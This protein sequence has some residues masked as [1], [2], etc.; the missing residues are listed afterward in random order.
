MPQNHSQ[1]IG[2]GCCRVL[3][4]YW[5]R[6]LIQAL[7]SG[8][9]EDLVSCWLLH[10]DHCQF[11]AIWVLPYGNSQHDNLLHQR[12][13]ERTR[14]RKQE[15]LCPAR[16]RKSL[17][18]LGENEYIYIYM[19]ESFRG[20]PETITTLLISYT[21]VQSKKLFKKKKKKERKKESHPLCSL[22][23]KRHLPD[24]PRGLPIDP[25]GSVTWL[26]EKQ[27][28]FSNGKLSKH[29]NTPPPNILFLGLCN[30]NL[31]HRS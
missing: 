1:G 11:L 21:P 19:A 15:D 30:I 7:S 22:P 31:L 18:S 28:S 27:P 3:K 23:S 14:E 4:S 17:W 8:S 29:L 6:I 20:L 26:R 9:W 12:K 5:K 24:S 16:V 10:K 13:Q 25:L 2:W